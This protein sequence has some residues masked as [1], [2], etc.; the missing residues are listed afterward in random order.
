MQVSR[1]IVAIALVG[2]VAVACGGSGATQAPGGATQA[3]GATQGGGGATNQ[4]QATQ[5][6]GDGTKPA[7]WDQYGKVSYEISAPVSLSGELGF[8]PVASVFGG[9]QGSTLS[10][11]YLGGSTVL[12]ISFTQGKVAISFGSEAGTVIG[13]DCTTSNLNIGSSSASGSFECTQVVA[14]MASG[15][16]VT[17]VTMKGNFNG[18]G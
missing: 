3:P 6:G 5:G 18:H 4:P 17:N 1:S 11:S 12:S 10:F 13:T 14:M 8:L 9:D 7:G 2:V 16:Q 15:G